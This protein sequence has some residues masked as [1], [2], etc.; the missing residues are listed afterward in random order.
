MYVRISSLLIKPELHSE[1]G[2]IDV[3]QR[4]IKFPL[5]L[6]EEHPF[7]LIKLFITYNLTALY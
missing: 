1:I 2:T 5:I 6:F 7:I 4:L 3:N